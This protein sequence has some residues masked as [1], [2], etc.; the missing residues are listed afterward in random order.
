MVL[1]CHSVHV[2]PPSPPEPSLTVIDPATLKLDWDPPFTWE[3]HSIIGYQIAMYNKSEPL[4]EKLPKL[5]T[6]VTTFNYSWPHQ[7]EL[8]GTMCDTLM[9]FVTAISDIGESA[10]GNVSGGFPIRKLITNCCMITEVL[11]LHYVLE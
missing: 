2:G 1:L 11:Q 8:L 5:S 6:N 3:N 7:D 9:F 4:G 10:M